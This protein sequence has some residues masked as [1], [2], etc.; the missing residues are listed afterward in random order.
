MSA[1]IA[2]MTSLLLT[3]PGDM[4]LRTPGFMAVKRDL[5]LLL[6]DRLQHEARAI[7]VRVLS[8]S[9]LGSG[10]VI[11]REGSVYTVVTNQH[12]LRGAKPPYRVQMPDG[13]I[14]VA[15]V[16]VGIDLSGYDLALL[17]FRSPDVV[18]AV[19][20]LGSAASLSVADE[21]FAA[22]FPAG[23]P[24]NPPNPPLLRGGLDENYPLL[25]GG[26]DENSS[27]PVGNPGNPPNPP[28][29]RGGLDNSTKTPHPTPHTPH[30]TPQDLLSDPDESL[31]Y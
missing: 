8:T 26:L 16:V 14:Y 11:Q 29:L 18:Y 3:L 28:L 20:R 5:P 17:Q 6:L 9:P 27:L 2:L 19:A 23:Y 7:T 24:G 22:G 31:W 10:I 13:Q 1:T 4:P 25:R 21:V 12:V 30:P 15:E